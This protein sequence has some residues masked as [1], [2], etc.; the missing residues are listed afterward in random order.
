[1]RRTS[2]FTRVFTGKNRH[3]Y[4]ARFHIGPLLIFKGLDGNIVKDWPDGSSIMVIMVAGQPSEK[5]AAV[6]AYVDGL[7]EFAGG[8][9]IPNDEKVNIYTRSHFFQIFVYIKSKKIIG[10]LI[11]HGVSVAR[12]VK[13]DSTPAVDAILS[14]ND[15]A[16]TPSAARSLVSLEGDDVPV[17]VGI[18]RIWVHTRHRRQGIATKLVDALRSHF[19]YGDT[20]PKSRIAM[21]QTSTPGTLFASHYFETPRF[22]IY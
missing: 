17:E 5:V 16:L 3:H 22:L 1:M 14:R 21:S 7:L 19:R 10:C 8:E 20:I 12:R 2:V 15:S 9:N 4:L 18:S 13:A 6:R 11:A